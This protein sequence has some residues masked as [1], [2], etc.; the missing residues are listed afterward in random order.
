[1]KTGI[2]KAI[3]ALVAKSPDNVYDGGDGNCYY[4]RG[5]C[6]DGSIGCIIGQALLA[7][8]YSQYE[9]EKFDNQTN[10]LTAL[11]VLRRLE[12]DENEAKFAQLCQESQDRGE[13]WV[14]AFDNALY[15]IENEGKSVVF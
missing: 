9:V 8:G 11:D 15:A 2:I 10:G 12:Y 7:E 13:K 4:A 6:T 3:Q 1:M 5:V 14:D